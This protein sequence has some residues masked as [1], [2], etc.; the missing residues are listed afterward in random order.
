VSKAR[1]D[2]PLGATGGNQVSLPARPR[3]RPGTSL[4]RD[5]PD[6]EAE[7]ILENCEQFLFRAKRKEEER[8][9]TVRKGGGQIWYSFGFGGFMGGW[10]Q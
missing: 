5:E 1:V 4:S 8:E 3:R 10:F 9:M 7:R 2:F 6:L